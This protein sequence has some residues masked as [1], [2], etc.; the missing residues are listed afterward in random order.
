MKFTKNSER[1]LPAYTKKE[2]LFN[3]RSHLFCLP[4]CFAIFVVCTVT[5][6]KYGGGFRMAAATVYGLCVIALYLASGLYHGA[7]DPRIKRILQTI[8]H[9][10]VYFMIAGT[11]TPFLFALSLTSPTIAYVMLGIEWG[12]TLIAATLTAIDIHKFRTFSKICYSLLT[13]LVVIAIKPTVASMPPLGSAFLFAGT[14]AYSVGMLFFA[15]GIKK[16]RMHN[17][18]HVFIILGTALH[19]IGAAGYALRS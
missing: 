17:V 16:R 15:L 3:S 4:F 11:Y 10:T 2:E 1:A 19:A 18:F 7:T 9:C 6:G 12:V 8:D 14:T 13:W 5:A